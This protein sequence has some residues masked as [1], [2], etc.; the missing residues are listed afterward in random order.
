MSMGSRYIGL[1][2]MRMKDRCHCLLVHSYLQVMNIP[3]CSLDEFLTANETD[4]FCSPL[5]EGININARML[6]R[7]RSIPLLYSPC[8]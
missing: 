1:L 6:L 7:E 2:P 3:V 4:L 5:R 8:S